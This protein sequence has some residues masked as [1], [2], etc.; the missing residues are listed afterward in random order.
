[1]GMMRRVGK[2]QQAGRTLSLEVTAELQGSGPTIHLA[3]T[4]HKHYPWEQQWIKPDIYFI[5]TQFTEK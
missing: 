4:R 3:H 2:E 5:I 1:M